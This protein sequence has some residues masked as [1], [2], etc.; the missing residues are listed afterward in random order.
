MVSFIVLKVKMSDSK[1][2]FEGFNE[3]E[4]LEIRNRENNLRI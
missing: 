1:N 3:A 4:V 2:E